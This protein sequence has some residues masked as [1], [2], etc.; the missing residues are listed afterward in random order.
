MAGSQSEV[1]NIA[2][3]AIEVGRSG[4][5]RHKATCHPRLPSLWPSSAPNVPKTGRVGA[6]TALNA[7][8]VPR[9]GTL[10]AVMP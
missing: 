7:P 3:T 5:G 8:N 10:G 4:T 2:R 1:T 6:K 9:T